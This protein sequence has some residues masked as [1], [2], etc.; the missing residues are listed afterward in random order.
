MRSGKINF[1]PLEIQ[2]L[3]NVFQDIVGD[4]LPLVLPP[5]RS[6][7]HQID[8]IPGSILP[9]KDPYQMT[10]AKSEEV[11]RKVQELFD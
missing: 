2:P 8:L 11:N 6:I 1:V 9:N 4:G 7:S 3:L 5:L 10:L